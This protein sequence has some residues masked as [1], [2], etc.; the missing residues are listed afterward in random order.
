MKKVASFNVGDKVFAKVKGYP[1]WPAMII[2]D[3]TTKFNVRFYGTG[4]TGIV[5][6]KD[7]FYYLKHK[8]NFIKSLKRKDYNE[9]IE[10]IE[11]AIE[12]N[13]G[14]DG[15]T[16][17]PDPIIENVESTGNNKNKRKRSELDKTNGNPAKKISIKSSDEIVPDTIENEKTIKK[18]VERSPRKSKA[19][20][21][22]N[23]EIKEDITETESSKDIEQMESIEETGDRSQVDAQSIQEDKVE[24]TTVTVVVTTTT[25]TIASDEQETTKGHLT[26]N[27]IKIVTEDYLS[28]VVSYADFVKKEE[29][30]YKK[31]P[32]EPRQQ[33]DNEVVLAKTPSGQY[34]GI[35][36]NK[37]IPPELDNEF[38]RAVYDATEASTILSLKKL[39]DEGK[40]DS[41]SDKDLLI[42]NI[43]IDENAIKDIRKSEVIKYKKEKINQL[44]IEANLIELDTKIKKSLGLDKAY[45]NE[46]IQYLDEILNLTILPIMLKKH[47][48]V[49]EMVKRIGRYTGNVGEWDFTKEQLE[50]FEGQAERVRNKADEVFSKFAKLFN[51]SNESLFW[52]TF[53]DEVEVFKDQLKH[54][55]ES[56]IFSLTLEP[57][58][59][60]SFIEKSEQLEEIKIVAA[61]QHKNSEPSACKF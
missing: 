52:K 25:P 6:S 41:E 56:E 60:Q 23:K 7:L 33:F 21:S 38:D 24:T 45:P 28:A 58:S 40:C 26:A 9:A 36:C 4:E 54:L 48:H 53:T 55:S 61:N 51:V 57:D 29:D 59:R 2:E 42:T 11:K 35:K 34:V 46:A 1:A 19:R 22:I 16:E 37:D 20:G 44:K 14:T 27:D 30:K 8:K 18:V 47:P 31:R 10:E 12:E 32:V 15:N 50:E 39:L 17:G 49:V 13:G 43:D 5:K 3:Q